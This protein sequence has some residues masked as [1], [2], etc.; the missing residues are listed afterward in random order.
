MVDAGFQTPPITGHIVLLPAATPHRP[1]RL[2]KDVDLLLA[3]TIA[4]VRMNQR[5]VVFE[6]RPGS[7]P[8]R[9]ARRR[10]R[11]PRR[12]SSR[13]AGSRSG[14]SGSC[15]PSGARRLIAERLRH[16]DHGDHGDRARSHRMRCLR[17]AGHPDV[18]RAASTQAGGLHEHRDRDVLLKA[19]EQRA[20]LLNLAQEE[21]D[22]CRLLSSLVGCCRP[23]VLPK[24]TP[25]KVFS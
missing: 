16:E 15:S 12:S 20:P 6:T 22:S 4:G 21:R 1:L 17:G 9:G 5:L 25:L 18:G 8:A 23:S 24:S 10:T 7:R 14:W 19:R 13:R 2:V 11:R 3:A